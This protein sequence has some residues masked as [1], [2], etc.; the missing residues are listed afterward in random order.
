MR[1]CRLSVAVAFSAEDSLAFLRASAVAVQVGGALWR[2]PACLA[3]SARSL[4][5]VAMPQSSASAP[6][7]V[8]AS[9]V[10]LGRAA[11]P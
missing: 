2:D 7:S 4:S 3:R 11:E 5:P 9:D 8:E 1:R 10:G 6:V